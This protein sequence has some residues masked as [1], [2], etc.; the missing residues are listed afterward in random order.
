MCELDLSFST[1]RLGWYGDE[2]SIRFRCQEGEEWKRKEAQT[3]RA[4]VVTGGA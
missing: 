4:A 3:N 1:P 2:V